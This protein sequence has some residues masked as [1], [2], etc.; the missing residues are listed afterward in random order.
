MCKQ[1]FKDSTISEKKKKENLNA[2]FPDQVDELRQWF[3]VFLC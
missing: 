2:N 1:M 3:S